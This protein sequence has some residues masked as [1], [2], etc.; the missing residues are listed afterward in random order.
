MRRKDREWNDQEGIE[1]ILQQCR[2]ANLALIDLQ[3]CP[4]SVPVH[5]GYSFEGGRL[6]LYFHGARE[7]KKA[8]LLTKNPKIAVCIYRDLG[9]K[10]ADSACA[11][12]AYYESVMVYGHARVLQTDGERKKGLDALM[13][14]LGGANLPY[15]DNELSLT[16]VFAVD[17][18]Q[19]T[20]K[21]RV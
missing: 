4:Y 21:R 6:T 5:F 10:K 20:A 19:V 2:I 1:E 15:D 16:A 8:E 9:L 17:V 12:G 11:F 18:E 7:G 14:K 13:T 3:G